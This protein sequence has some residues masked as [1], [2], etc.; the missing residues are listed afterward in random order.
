[1][2]NKKGEI[3]TIFAISVFAVLSITT[4]ISAVLFNSSKQT[5]N[6]TRAAAENC[7]DFGNTDATKSLA[8]SWKV[9]DCSTQCV[10]TD[11]DISI[12]YGSDECTKSFSSTYGNNREDYWC[13]Y[14]DDTPNAGRCLVL[15][16]AE[17]RPANPTPLPTFTP[18]PIPTHTPTPTST[19]TLSATPTPTPTNLPNTPIPTITPIISS[20]LAPT[21]FCIDYEKNS[22][23]TI[24]GQSYCFNETT[25]R[26]CCVGG[27]Q[28]QSSPCYGKT[29]LEELSCSKSNMTC[30]QNGDTALCVYPT[31]TPIPATSTP[32]PS[33]I[34]TPSNT[35]T[36]LAPSSTPTP[37]ISPTATPTPKPIP[38][39]EALLMNGDSN[40]KL[41]IVFL[42]TG[43]TNLDQLRNSILTEINRWYSGSNIGRDRLNKLNF[44]L[45]TDLTKNFNDGPVVKDNVYPHLTLNWKSSTQESKRCAGDI[46]LVIVNSQ[47]WGGYADFGIGAV[48]STI[49]MP[50][51]EHELSHAIGYMHD[52]YVPKKVDAPQSA[53]VY[54]QCYDGVSRD[55][56]QPCIKW[57]FQYQKSSYP[58]MGCYPGC[59]YQN[60]FRAYDDDIMFQKIVDNL[61]YTPIQ[62]DLWDRNTKSYH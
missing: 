9:T 49:T 56:T 54:E 60:W 20:T 35:P 29:N 47:T 32:T 41:D 21:P 12:K 6:S 61:I 16:N 57:M 25:K 13:Y 26:I 24:G 40:S 15:K 10:L 48:V 11:N 8:E 23:T 1:M 58:Q 62:L 39:C 53:K 52:E 59:N 28:D 50:A 34:P 17:D 5:G 31:S 2:N 33:T 22:K 14:F 27:S 7:S 55:Q 3:A 46:F 44:T 42:S 45:Y 4:M 30:I 43:Y 18:T 37:S 36:P 19:H 51:M 38:L